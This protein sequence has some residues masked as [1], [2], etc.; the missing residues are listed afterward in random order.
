MNKFWE[1]IVRHS[2]YYYSVYLKFAKRV[3]IK[4]SYHTPMKRSLCKVIEVVSLIV[5]IISQCTGRSNH[6]IVCHNVCQLYLNVAGK[7]WKA[8]KE[9]NRINTT[10]FIKFL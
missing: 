10:Y 2:D 9:K 8:E 3:N 6:H 7:K 5:V 1:S 4:C